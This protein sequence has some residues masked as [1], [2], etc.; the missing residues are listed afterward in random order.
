MSAEAV[1]LRMAEGAAAA[2]ADPYIHHAVHKRHP[3]LNLIRYLVLALALV[4]FLFPIFWI[5]AT[6]FKM[7]GE[8]LSRPPVWIPSDPTLMHYR[9]VMA[10]KG[11]PALTNST[12]IATSATL[13]ALLVGTLA[14][15]SLARFNTG[16]KHFA[17][18]LLSQRMMPPV[19][20]IVPFFLL[21]RDTGQRVSFF[22]LDDRLSLIAI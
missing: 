5:T 3:L 12:I 1:E 19:V 6:S 11:W 22:G 15:Y 2:K 4:F 14:G 17:F 8:Y 10:D 18:W 7:P 9:N 21:L 13:L 16:G 20:L